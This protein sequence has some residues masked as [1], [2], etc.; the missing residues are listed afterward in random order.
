MVFI[1]T[2]FVSSG[3]YAFMFWSL[4]SAGITENGSKPLIMLLITILALKRTCL[5]KIRPSTLDTNLFTALGSPLF[6]K[7]KHI[8]VLIL[9]GKLRSIANILKLL[10]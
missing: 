4:M 2:R 9:V 5:L 6:F 8:G 7:T 1:C 3:Y 10:K